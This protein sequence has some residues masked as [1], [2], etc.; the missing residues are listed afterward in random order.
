VLLAALQPAD[1]KN[2]APNLIDVAEAG[3]LEARR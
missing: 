3:Q 1:S 2:A